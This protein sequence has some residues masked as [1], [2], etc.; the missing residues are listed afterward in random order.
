LSEY[1]IAVGGDP[2]TF[3]QP[4]K[5]RIN[6]RIGKRVRQNLEADVLVRNGRREKGQPSR[7][8]KSLILSYTLLSP[9]P[10]RESR[11]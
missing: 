4:E 9:G 1:E 5:A 11:K 2:F 7:R 8:K 10:E 6:R 3:G